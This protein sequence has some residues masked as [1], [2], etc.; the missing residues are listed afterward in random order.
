ML[1]VWIKRD[2]PRDIPILGPPLCRN[3]LLGTLLSLFTS[4]DGNT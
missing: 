4:V 1:D 2:S 3:K